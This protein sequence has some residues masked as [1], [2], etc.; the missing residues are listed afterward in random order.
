MFSLCS[1][2]CYS[3][4]YTN[5]LGLG[6]APLSRK[7]KKVAAV[8]DTTTIVSMCGS[9]LFLGILA[10]FFPPVAGQFKFSSSFPSFDMGANSF[11]HQ[12]GSR[13]AFALLTPLSTS[14]SAVLATS[15]V[16]ST[17]GTSSSRTPSRITM[18][19][20]TSPSL[21]AQDGTS[22]VAR[23]HTTTFPTSPFNNHR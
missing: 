15:P 8:G 21:V 13:W 4:I 3:K 17:H 1:V 5:H 12:S 9:D 22:R 2:I 6:F 10:V 14:L 19:S 16:S 23:P 11:L 18:M 7:E 20:V